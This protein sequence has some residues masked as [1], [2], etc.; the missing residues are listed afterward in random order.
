MATHAFDA[1]AVVD[2]LRFLVYR[3]NRAT[4]NTHVALLATLGGVG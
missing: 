1:G 3:F 2:F 4:L